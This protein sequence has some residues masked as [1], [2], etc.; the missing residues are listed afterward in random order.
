[1]KK[2][3]LLTKFSQAINWNILLYTLYKACFM[4]VSYLLYKKI[5][6]FYFSQWAMG[7]ALI[8]L[9]LLWIDPGFK[10]SIPRF[11]P[12]FSQDPKYHTKFIISVVSLQFLLLL[13]ALIPYWY[14]IPYFISLQNIYFI[15]SM[16][17]VTEGIGTIFQ[18]MYHAHFK[19]KQFN[20]LQISCTM[21][22]MALNIYCITTLHDDLTLVKALFVTKIIASC[23]I[24]IGSLCMISTLYSDDLLPQ[25]CLHNPRKIVKEFLIHSLL[26]WL[27]TLIKSITERNFLFPYITASFGAITANMFK[28]SHDGALFFQRIG[29]KAL[30]TADTA[31]LSY[32][33]I[34]SASNSEQLSRAF[35][36]IVRIV[37][38][39]SLSL[40]I[41][42]FLL[43]CIR[44]IIGSN[45]LFTLFII[46]AIGYMIEIFLSPY[47]RLLE[48]QRQYKKL[49]ISYTPYI[50]V[51]T[52]LGVMHYYNHITLTLLQ[53]ICIIHLM[54]VIGSISMALFARKLYKK[55]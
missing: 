21:V 5:S 9:G 1:M 33:Q 40:G 32:V 47:E 48:V 28:I 39:L 35:A 12:I 50:I 42:G 53:I 31:L 2:E 43:F 26:M 36:Y 19:Y 54:R 14:I 30:G 4:V 41:I 45:N 46:V 24:I 6:A 15:L 3:I 44:N 22:E 51:I 17:F 38:I 16:L 13:G 34:K 20:L 23:A 37:S 18:I 52:F 11:Y 25:A 7:N 49:W 27:S 55:C 8:F 10:K 29:L